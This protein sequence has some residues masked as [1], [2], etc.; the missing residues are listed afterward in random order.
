MDCG[1]ITSKMVILFLSLIF[2]AAGGALVYVGSYVIKSYSNFDNFLQDKYTFI[3]AGIIIPT[4]V[5]MFIIGTVG[6]YA[7]LSES[8]VGLSFFL[9]IILAIFAAGHCSSLW[10]HLP[11]QDKRELGAVNECCVHEV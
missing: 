7:T 10:V 1:I 2:W 6:C 5:V 3:P 4:G 9:L 11:K 8:K